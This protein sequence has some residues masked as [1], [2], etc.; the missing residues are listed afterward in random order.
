MPNSSNLN[1][2]CWG[3]NMFLPAGVVSRKC[4]TIRCKSN[5]T[6][7]GRRPTGT[8]AKRSSSPGRSKSFIKGGSLSSAHLTFVSANCLAFES[9]VYPV[10]SILSPPMLRTF[11]GRNPCR[12]SRSNW[13]TK[14]KHRLSLRRN[15][16]TRSLP[17]SSLVKQFNSK[18]V[19]ISREA[20]TTPPNLSRPSLNFW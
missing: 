15:S 10:F 20:L 14:P 11:F 12:L 19:A 2:N 6:R 3:S 16:K 17:F 13:R 18:N 1:I 5:I 8:T 9:L 4:F 7:C